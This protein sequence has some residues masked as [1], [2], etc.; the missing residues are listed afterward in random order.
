MT[1]QE[2][3]DRLREALPAARVDV[4]TDDNTHFEALVVDAGFDGMR[5]IARHQKVYAILGDAVGR[6]IHALALKTLTP[7]EFDARQGGL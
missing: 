4:R 2:I 3:T 5:S 1:A 6:E 7:E